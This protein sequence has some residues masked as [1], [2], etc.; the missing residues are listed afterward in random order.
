M[1]MLQISCQLVIAVC[2]LVYLFSLQQSIGQ[3]REGEKHEQH[4]RRETALGFLSLGFT[5]AVLAVMVI[6]TAKLLR[7]AR[8]TW[9]RLTGRHDSILSAISAMTRPFGTKSY[10]GAVPEVAGCE[11]GEV[12]PQVEEAGFQNV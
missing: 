9:L 6:G 7:G 12:G 5:V 1:E 3:G 8:A 2:M 10:G 11:V 4:R